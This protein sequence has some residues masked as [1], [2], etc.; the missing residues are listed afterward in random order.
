MVEKAAMAEQ[1]LQ[2][3]DDRLEIPRLS[4]RARARRVVLW[5][6]LLATAAATYAYYSQ[7]EPVSELYRTDPV[8]R[9]SLVHRVEATGSLDVRSRV[10]VPAPIAG[11]LTE[12]HVVSGEKVE[13]GQ[14]LASLD[15]R[16]AELSLKSAQATVQAASG[17]VAEARVALEAA[18]QASTHAKRLHEKGLASSQ[19]ATE[20]DSKAQRARATLDAARAERELAS[21]TVASARLGKSLG[22][23]VAPSAGIVLRAP[24]RLG[25]AVSPERGPLFVLGDPLDVMRVDAP[26]SESD[27]ARIKPEMPATISV[28]ALPGKTF[29]ARVQQIAIDPIRDKG[30][31]LYP[32]ILF[33]D[34]PGRELL[35][36]MSARVELEVARVADVLSVHD[37]ALRFA[38][39]DSAALEELGGGGPRTR[40]WRRVGLAEIEPVVVVVGLSDGVYTQVEPAPG[41]QLLEGDALAIGLL[42]PDDGAPKPQV[43]LGQK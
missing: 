2:R 37:A 40:G 7:P 4:R 25:A 23:I 12:I 24:E 38:P 20:A 43:S 35:P 22:S 18:I 42:R 41:A 6:V 16:A 30:L 19:D 8:T 11:R 3:S 31:V 5:L 9:R 14:L 15:E 13:A 36:G 26:V 34:N 10:E 29:S 28:P 27:I 32:V 33:V 17:R 1:T 21:Q 39:A